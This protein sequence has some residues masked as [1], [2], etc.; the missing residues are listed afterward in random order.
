M[1]VLAADVMWVVRW[2]DHSAG[3]TGWGVVFALL[4]IFSIGAS[5]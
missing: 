1:T 5:R 2:S 4:L 3:L